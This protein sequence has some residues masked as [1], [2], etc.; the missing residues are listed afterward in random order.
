[1]QYLF[2]T[3]ALM[4][5]A[6]FGTQWFIN[7][8]AHRLAR[9]MRWI[10]AGALSVAAI[11]L[12]MRGQLHA[13]A[14]LLTAA[15]VLANNGIYG[16]QRPKSERQASVV[17][18]RFLEM[19]LEH[20]TGAMSGV[21]LEGDRAGAELAGLT[22]PELIGL[23]ARYAASDPPSAALLETYLDWAHADW[24]KNA[25]DQER[26]T[27]P[28]GSSGMSIAEARQILGV[29]ADATPDEIREAWREQMRRNHPDRGGSSYLAAKI[30]EAKD[31]LLGDD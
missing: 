22:R 20:D 8:N 30:N 12:L 10:T 26:H 9:N 13:T 2:G 1:M 23:L 31:V 7:A 6:T 14:A 3:I 4:V 21:V 5:L 18:T 11:V 24:R 28:S 19:R 15:L 29:G 16:A 25:G 27:S 17:R